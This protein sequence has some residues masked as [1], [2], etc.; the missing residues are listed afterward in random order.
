MEREYD[1]NDCLFD[2][3]C[4]SGWAKPKFLYRHK[5]DKDVYQL[6]IMI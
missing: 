5:T 2:V 1:Y 3:L 6:K 4:R